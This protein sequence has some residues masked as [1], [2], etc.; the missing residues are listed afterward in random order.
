LAYRVRLERLTYLA[1]WQIGRRY[2]SMDEKALKRIDS[3]YRNMKQLTLLAVL[4]IIVPILLPFVPLLCLAYLYLRSRLLAEIDSG[5]I[6]IDPVMDG[7]T[8]KVGEIST[9]HKLEYIRN[10]GGRLWSI[11]LIVVSVAVI[12][13]VLIIAYGGL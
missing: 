13:C 9:I 10:A 3:L 6:P 4:A 5:K 1:Q 2:E 8:A 11:L 7:Q 12:I